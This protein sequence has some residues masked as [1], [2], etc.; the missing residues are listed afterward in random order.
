MTMT[1]AQQQA[2]FFTA[3]EQSDARST[4]AREAYADAVVAILTLDPTSDLLAGAKRVADQAREAQDAITNTNDR[5]A[6]GDFEA[7][8]AALLT[9]IRD[10]SAQ[11]LDAYQ[12]AALITL[13]INASAIAPIDYPRLMEVIAAA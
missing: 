1:Q 8:Q 3:I 2:T 10:A 11:R 12:R 13:G 4:G 7:D 9:T 6:Q 5:L